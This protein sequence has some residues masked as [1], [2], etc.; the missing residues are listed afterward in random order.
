MGSQRRQ[1]LAGVWLRGG[2]AGSSCSVV[3]ED[4]GDRLAVGISWVVE[5]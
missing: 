3:R 2:G 4:E 1:A 5:G